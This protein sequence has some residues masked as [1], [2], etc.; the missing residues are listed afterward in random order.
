MKKLVCTLGM[1]LVTFSSA[2]ATTFVIENKCHTYVTIYTIKITKPDYPSLQFYPGSNNIHHFIVNGNSI[3]EISDND[4][5]N[6]QFPF[7]NQYPFAGYVNSDNGGQVN[8]PLPFATQNDRY[9]FN[10]MKF[11]LKGAYEDGI[12]TYG[13][14]GID[15]ATKTGY[16]YEPNGVQYNVTYTNLFGMSYFLFE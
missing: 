8:L 12:G 9:K 3:F 1:A 6:K 5:S 11:V 7:L 15:G 13:T 10:Y 2:N 16:F 4:S 14:N